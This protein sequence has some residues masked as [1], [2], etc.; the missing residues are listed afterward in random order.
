[1]FKHP[2]SQFVVNGD[3]IGA[4]DLLFFFLCGDFIGRAQK[5]LH[6]VAGPPKPFYYYNSKGAG[7]SKYI[8]YSH[9]CNF[10]AQVTMGQC[11]ITSSKTVLVFL[12]LI[13]WVRKRWMFE[14]CA[15][16]Q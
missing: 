16:S 7:A 3:V 14:Q 8:F 2:P 12:N 4:R 10:R 1:M 6:S 11:G 5:S 13:F 9:S 15:A